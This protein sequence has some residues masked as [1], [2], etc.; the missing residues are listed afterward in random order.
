[1]NKAELISRS[2][3]LLRAK[4]GWDVQQMAFMLSMWPSAIDAIES[5]KVGEI[6]RDG[7][8]RR[9]KS[10]LG[11]DMTIFGWCNFGDVNLLPRGVQE[12]ANAL[13]ESWDARIAELV[14]EAKACEPKS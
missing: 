4:L 12:A 3:R 13:T 8:E 5:G 9:V 1:M 2:A 6:V 11:I 14:A 10:V 7:Y